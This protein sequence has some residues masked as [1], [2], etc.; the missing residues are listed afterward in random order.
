MDPD[1]VASGG[2]I[3]IGQGVSQSTSPD[4]DYR[5][6]LL[7]QGRAFATPTAYQ[8]G[9]AFASPNQ[10]YQQGTFANSE[11]YGQAQYASPSPVYQPGHYVS[12]NYA[13]SPGNQHR[14][15]YNP[16]SYQPATPQVVGGAHT[17]YHGA[18]GGSYYQSQSPNPFWQTPY[19]QDQNN[20]YQYYAGYGQQHGT[21]M[22]APARSVNV[23]DAGQTPTRNADLAAQ[24]HNLE[25]GE[26]ADKD[27]GENSGEKK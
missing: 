19:L 13:L 15:Q 25:S 5:P 26:Q 10:S 17:P 16:S 27:I 12:P 4:T 14:N 6:V 24:Q 8:Q 3:G 11:G 22:G 1:V 2:R 20:G 9:R 21:P 7:T 18:G 23:T